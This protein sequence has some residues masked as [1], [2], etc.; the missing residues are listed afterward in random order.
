METIKA[1]RRSESRIQPN[2]H[3]GCGVTGVQAEA[4]ASNSGAQRAQVSHPEPA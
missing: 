4:G 3:F 2:E 1:V